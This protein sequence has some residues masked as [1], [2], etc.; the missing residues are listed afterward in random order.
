V[1]MEKLQLAMRLDNNE[2]ETPDLHERI[3]VD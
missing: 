3:V 1:K 2:R